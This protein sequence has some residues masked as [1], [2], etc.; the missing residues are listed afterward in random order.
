MQVKPFQHRFASSLRQFD[1]KIVQFEHKWKRFFTPPPTATIKVEHVEQK[2]KPIVGYWFM[3]SG[4]LVFTI[5][6]VGGL[7]RLTESGLSITEWNVIRGMKPPLNEQ[8]WETE[9]E[10]YKQFPEYKL[11]NHHMT[12]PE[13]KFIFYMEWGHRMLG[14]FIGL[15]VILPGAYFWSRG[16]L[17]SG[18]KTRFLLISG[19]V[20]VQ[21]LLGWLM[22]KSGLSDE[23]L[24]NKMVPRVNHFWLSAHLGSAFLIYTAMISSGLHV[25]A[26][27]AKTVGT[28]KR[29]RAM[30]HGITAL[31][32]FTA[33]TGAWVAGLDAGLLYNEFPYMGNGLV[34]SDMWAYSTPSA[35]NPNPISWWRNLL[36]NPSAVQFNHRVMAVTTF[37]GI[38][39]LWLMTRRVPLARASRIAANSLM[40]VAILQVSLGISTLVLFVPTYLAAAHQAGSLT[41]LTMGIW[42]M[43]TLKK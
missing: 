31:I 43:H 24:E 13:F 42:L 18:M 36:E 3:L 10:K 41:L 37:T 28:P 25:L 11:L 22:V 16:Y 34:P 30:A 40:G 2:T 39:A 33:I 15:T 19:M 27:E 29:I 9:F 4:A 5:V 38:S 8:E 26:S 14:R 32:F 17:S 35:G 21:G 23:I 1:N 7:T 20:G 12:L 6:V